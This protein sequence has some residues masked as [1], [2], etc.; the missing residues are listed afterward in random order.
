MPVGI[1][2]A[3]ADLDRSTATARRRRASCRSTASAWRCWC[4]GSARCRS[5]STRARSST[6]SHPA[7]SSRWPSS[8]CVGFVF[9][10]VWELTDEHPVV[11]L[12]LF[13]RRNFGSARSRCRSATALF[14][15]NVVLLPLW[16]QTVHGLHRR[17]RPAS[18][19][20]RSACS[21]SC[22][23]R[24]WAGNMRRSI[25]ACSPRWR[26]CC[27]R[28]CCSCARTSTRRPTSPR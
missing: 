12:R 14:F 7:R 20:R 22:C 4:S 2:A 16:L 13:A 27:S 5:C 21:R 19:W 26:S 1:F 23:R 18:C 17:P 11:D 3:C 25:R 9:F 24:S 8:R 15:G 28:W 10:L 6:G